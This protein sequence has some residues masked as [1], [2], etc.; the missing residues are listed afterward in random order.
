MVPSVPAVLYDALE[1]ATRDERVMRCVAKPVKLK[2]RRTR[3]AAG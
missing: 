3:S 2:N 1:N